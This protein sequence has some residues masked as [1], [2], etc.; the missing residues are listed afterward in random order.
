MV[1]DECY[2]RCCMFSDTISVVPCIAGANHFIANEAIMRSIDIEDQFDSSV[3]EN[4]L[5]SDLLNIFDGVMGSIWST[6]YYLEAQKAS[7]KCRGWGWGFCSGRNS[8][9]TREQ[10]EAWSFAGAN[11]EDD[12][13]TSE[14]DP[15]DA[16][17]LS[18]AD[19]PDSAKT[20]AEE[21]G[22]TPSEGLP[23]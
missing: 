16:A 8:D 1:C 22:K 18:A 6:D 19:M 21:Y 12:E 2:E 3:P 5:P 14:A 23:L 20:A 4:A 13:N 17:L 7:C 15:N 9:S 11:P 10:E